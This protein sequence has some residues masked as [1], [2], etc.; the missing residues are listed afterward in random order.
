LLGHIVPQPSFAQAPPPDTSTYRVL[1][2]TYTLDANGISAQGLAQRREPGAPRLP[3]HG[4]MV[5]L[6]SSGGYELVTDLG[7]ETLLRAPAPLPPEPVQLFGAGAPAGEEEAAPSI[8]LEDRPDPAIYQADAFWPAAAVET[9]EVVVQQGRRLLPVRVYPFRYNPLTGQVSYRPDITVTVRSH[10]SAAVGLAAAADSPG[11]P[12]APA[13]ELGAVRISTA[14]RG[15]Y[16]LSYD[17]LNGRLFPSGATPSPD[18]FVMT[19]LGQPVRI[20]VRDGNSNNS[21]DPGDL[22]I[23]FAE[24]YVGRYARNNTYRLSYG[25]AAADPVTTRMATRTASPEAPPVVTAIT[26]TQRIE[27]DA[28]Y[29]LYPV[30][31]GSGQP[32]TARLPRDTDHLFEPALYANEGVPVVTRVYSFLPDDPI[33]SGPAAV[34]VTARVLGVRDAG[35]AYGQTPDHAVQLRLNGAALGSFGWDGF[36]VLTPTVATPATGLVAGQNTVSLVADIAGVTSSSGR[37]VTV[38][39]DWVELSYPALPDVAGETDAIYVEAI[40]TTGTSAQLPVTGFSSSAVNAYDVRDPRAPVQLLSTVAEG[41]GPYTIRVTDA[42]NDGDPVP[43]YWLSSD[44][45]LIAPGSADVVADTPSSWRTPGVNADYIAVVHADIWSAIDPLVARRQSQGLRVAKVDVQD[46][47]DEW[48]YGRVSPDA[49]REF[50]AYAYGNWNAGD[51]PPGYVL[52][53]GDGHVDFKGTV[54]GLTLKNL[55][56]PY[57]VEVDPWLNETAADNRYVSTDGFD[58]Y[59]AEM[60]IGRIPANT[61]AQVSDVVAKILAYEDPVQAP[62]GDWQKRVVFVAD[63][64]LDPTNDFHGMSDETRLNWLPAGYDDRTIYN[65]PSGHPNDGEMPVAI[66]GAFDEGAVALQWFGHGSLSRWGMNAPLWNISQPPGLAPNA[67]LPFVMHNTCY[68]GFFANI[69]LNR[70]SLGETHLL[71]PGRGAIADYSPSGLH[72]GGSLMVLNQAL[73]KALFQDGVTVVGDA[74]MHALTY[75]AANGVAEDLIDTMVLYG[76]PA[77]RLRVDGPPNPPQLKISLG[78][79]GVLIGWD[80]THYNTSYSVWRS[81][82]PY[83]DPPGGTLQ[84]AG[85][86][87]SGAIYG[88]PLQATD[89]PGGPPTTNYFWSALGTSNWG[90][91]PPSNRVGRFVYDLAP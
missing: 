64:I 47:Y 79:P 13:A 24:P 83:A 89:D 16:R 75:A 63:T 53:V 25:S 72:V 36:T 26:Q 6:P 34:K 61:A 80:H 45:K 82:L 29:W 57:L 68:S 52:L 50:L 5:P 15:M 67:R 58:D 39:P 14:Q 4:V 32:R 41:S 10:E 7:R 90:S 27:V 40:D 76:D 37:L 60:A 21:F 17:S 88:E 77:L 51:A 11:S 69:L 66:K 78:L 55:I 38:Y 3:V 59:M 18:A 84:V 65:D 1:T 20:Q 19:Y 28:R 30:A 62:P 86:D 85:V 35:E 31:E 9:G 12:A 23:F 49:I 73:I 81:E 42:W 91:S 54:S 74:V 46:I 22:V 33:T 2:P 43:A 71:Q 44:E 48:S 8:V 70:Q 56:P 87:A